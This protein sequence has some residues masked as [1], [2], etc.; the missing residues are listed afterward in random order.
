[1]FGGL[2]S[3]LFGATFAADRDILA[4]R[5]PFGLVSAARDVDRD[6]DL[7]LGVKLDRRLVLA[8]H[9]DRHVECDL[10]AVDLEAVLGEQLGEIARRYRA[11][12]LA[13]LGGLAQHREAFAIELLADLVGVALGLEVL[14]L[15]VGLHPLEASL[16]GFGRAQRLAL[17]QQKVAGKA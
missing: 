14:G 9:L 2:G 11:V 12:E 3:I 4:A 7:D 5:K 8:D 17:R 1:R 13:G 16:V 10:V 15:E 6:R